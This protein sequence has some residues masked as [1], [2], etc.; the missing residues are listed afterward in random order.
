[1]Q[2][3]AKYLS[4]HFEGYFMCRIATDPDPTDETHG[5]SGYTM[6]LH[7]EPRL[8]QVIRLQP[9]GKTALRKP[10]KQL[11]IQIG[12]CV[13]SVNYDGMFD[14]KATSLLKG[15][16]VNLLGQDDTF[17]GPTFVSRNNT[18]GS[19]DTMAFV[20]EPFEL[21]IEH[22]INGENVEIHAVDYP[23]PADKELLSW[24]IDQPKIYSRRLPT[25]FLSGSAE[26]HQ[27][28][29]VYD[30]YGY[31]RDRRRWLNEQIERIQKKL[32]ENSLNDADELKAKLQGYRSRLFQLETWGDR[33]INKLGFLCQWDFLING[34]Q[35]IIPGRSALEKALGGC[36]DCDQKWPV[37]FWFGGWDGDL[38]TGYMRGTL[39]LPLS[40]GSSSC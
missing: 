15:A 8:D 2:P 23:V 7:G 36:I 13:K 18:V 38:L 37:R 20:V 34:E 16:T 4:L 1:M 27:A 6:A 39:D 22:Q 3:E 24:E 31:F 5:T 32:A 21:S 28:I 40:Q 33:V 30:E 12:V 19:D 17:D 14:A 29:G 35:E 11:G 10:A 26:A 25:Q 9:D